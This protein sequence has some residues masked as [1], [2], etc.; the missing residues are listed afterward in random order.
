MARRLP[1]MSDGSRVAG[2]IIFSHLRRIPFDTS[3]EWRAQIL[4]GNFATAIAPQM[5]FGLRAL[6]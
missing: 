6:P 3:V 1:E 5:G 2:M 4:E